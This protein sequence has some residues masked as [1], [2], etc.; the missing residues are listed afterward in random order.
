MAF[1]GTGPDKGWCAR[2]SIRKTKP[3]IVKLIRQWQPASRTQPEKVTRKYPTTG[4][5]GPANTKR[6]PSED[7]EIHRQTGTHHRRSGN[8]KQTGD[9]WLISG[10]RGGGGKASKAPVKN[11]IGSGLSRAAAARWCFRYDLAQTPTIPLDT[12]RARLPFPTGYGVGSGKVKHCTRTPSFTSGRKSSSP[13]DRSGFG[14]ATRAEI[15]RIKGLQRIQT[16]HKLV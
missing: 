12:V 1:Y 2:K 3:V 9:D 11:R 10:S 14:P 4:P 13:S 6:S 7:L 5:A 8:V 16:G 15:R